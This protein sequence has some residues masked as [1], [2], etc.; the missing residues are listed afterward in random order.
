MPVT[1]RLTAELAG[2]YAFNRYSFIGQQWDSVGTDRVD[3]DPGPFV[4]LRVSLR[5]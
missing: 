3:I 4:S 1:S 2:G 5:R